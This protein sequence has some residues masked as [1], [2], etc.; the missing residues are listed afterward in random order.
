[1]Q[2][3]DSREAMGGPEPKRRP[4]LD[5]SGAPASMA[6]GGR[7]WRGKPQGAVLERCLQHDVR[8][9]VGVLPD[10]FQSEDRCAIEAVRTSPW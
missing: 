7:R 1:M 2:S 8:V 4:W 3:E 5:H 6:G 9:G 10:A